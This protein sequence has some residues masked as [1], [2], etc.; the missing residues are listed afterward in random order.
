MVVINVIAIVTGVM[1]LEM[2]GSYEDA[3]LKSNARKLIDVCDAASNR[4]IAAH[5]AQILKIDAG[6]GKFVVKTKAPAAEESDAQVTQGELDKRIALMIRQPERED[7][8]D[9]A[10]T[11]DGAGDA[12][13]S[14][15]IT[16]YP[17]G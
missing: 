5:Q 4:A 6:S 9:D 11:T 15:A 2:G 16:F 17:D 3:L 10:E 13:K 14:D 12:A 1:V 7:P 8:G